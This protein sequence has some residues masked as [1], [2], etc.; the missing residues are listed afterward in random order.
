MPSMDHLIRAHQSI[1]RQIRAAR[2]RILSKTAMPSMDC[3]IRARQ[4]IERQI[5]ARQTY[6]IKN[7]RFLSKTAM[8]RPDKPVDKVR[9]RW[10]GSTE[11][12]TWVSG[13]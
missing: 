9:G 2:V 13:T 1:N 3:Q 10:T 8:S 7:V 4:S 5:R 12:A 6:Q 11:T